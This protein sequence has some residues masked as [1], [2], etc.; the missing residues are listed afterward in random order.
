MTTDHWDEDDED[1]DDDESSTVVLILFHSRKVK[2]SKGIINMS[3]DNRM[4][5]RDRML[6]DF[7]ASFLSH[8]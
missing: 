4:D 1:A 2:I 6:L 3:D 8:C 5:G 7:T